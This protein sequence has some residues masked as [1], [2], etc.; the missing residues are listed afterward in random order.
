MN[1]QSKKDII[2]EQVKQVNDVNLINAIKNILDYALNIE[3]EG[4][5]IT[6]AHQKLVMDRFNK[7]RKT[8]ESLLDWNEAKKTLNA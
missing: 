4:I 2:I 5:D 7:V 8:P 6:E 1:I 3:K